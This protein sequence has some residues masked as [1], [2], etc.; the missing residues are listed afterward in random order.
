LKTAADALAIRTRILRAF[1]LA[2]RETDAER[3]KELLTFVIVGGGPTGVEMAGA[4]SEMAHATLAELHTP[5][6]GVSTSSFRISVLVEDRFVT[7]A[8]RLLH[9]RLVEAEPVL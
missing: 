9:E 8:V 2:E 3:R 1:E 5:V 6:L 7:D 4:L